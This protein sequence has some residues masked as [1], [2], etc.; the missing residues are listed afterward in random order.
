MID[1]TD[2]M[3]VLASCAPVDQWTAIPEQ[4]VYEHGP[5]YDSCDPFA[6]EEIGRLQE[7]PLIDEDNNEVPVFNE[8]G[9][10]VPR[11]IPAINV[12]LGE[13]GIWMKLN[14]LYDLFSLD[15]AEDDLYNGFRTHEEDE[16]EY[17]V[18]VYP[19]AFTRTYGHFQCNTV[20]GCMTRHIHDVNVNVTD[21]Q[22]MVQPDDYDP[23]D[24]RQRAQV[25]FQEVSLEALGSQGYNASMHRAR[26]PGDRW[27]EVQH[28]IVT[29][30]MAGSFCTSVK[31]KATAA[32][33]RTKIHG[34]HGNNNV[35]ER[36]VL[37]FPHSRTNSRL[38]SARD[39]SFRFEINYVVNVQM[40]AGEH[41]TGR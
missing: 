32:T 26:G 17:R 20:P 13:Y 24:R 21:P 25:E 3:M 31:N 7:I 6:R 9:L 27:H 22:Q 35:G 8:Q 40:L 23:G 33:L 29:G 38:G 36:A 37:E 1:G 14:K 39:E 12:G 4:N 18:H 2:S 5:L 11:R 10:R 41:R 34:I 16:G 28:G 30:A 19:Q 15:P